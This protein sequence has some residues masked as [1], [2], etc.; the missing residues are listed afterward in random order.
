MHGVVSP[1]YD[2]LGG[3]E[4]VLVVGRHAGQR[5]T[6][7]HISGGAAALPECMVSTLMTPDHTALQVH[8][9]G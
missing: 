5:Q 8:I 9:S 1:D 6:V 2:G 7:G 4:M 3:A